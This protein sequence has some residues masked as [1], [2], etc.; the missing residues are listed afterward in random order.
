MLPWHALVRAEPYCFPSSPSL[1]IRGSN[2]Q[3]LIEF[4][5]PKPLGLSILI[6][7]TT[8]SILQLLSCSSNLRNISVHHRPSRSESVSYLLPLKWKM[9]P[10]DWH[11]PN[12][13]TSVANQRFLALH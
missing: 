5:K 4:S 8:L 10:F 1:E 12:P 11:L 13:D 2:R 7:L 3:A 9:E 6:K